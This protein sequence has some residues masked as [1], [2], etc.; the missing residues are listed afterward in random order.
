MN[1]DGINQTNLTNNSALERRSTWSPDGTKIAFESNRD[2]DREIYQMSSTGDNPINLTNS[3]G[4]DRQ[5]HWSSDGTKIAFI[6]KRD[7]NLEVYVM[8]S[9]GTDSTRLTNESSNDGF[10]A[11]SNDGTKIAFDS[12]RDG[13]NEIYV[14]D[15][16]RFIQGY[17][18]DAAVDFK[19]LG[20]TV[21]VDP[22]YFTTPPDITPTTTCA[23]TTGDISG[24]VD[25]DADGIIL[26]VYN[27]SGS[28]KTYGIREVGSSYS[29]TSLGLRGNENT[30]YL[31]GLNASKEFQAYLETTDVKIYL[32]GQTKGS[33]V[34]Y[35]DDKVVTDPTT[36]SWQLLDADDY[37]IP[38]AANGLVFLAEQPVAGGEPGFR[39][40]DSTDDWNK[41]VS[42]VTHIQAGVGLDDDNQW[43][44]YMQETSAD[45]FIAAYTLPIGMDVHADMDVLIRQADGSV[46]TT[47]ATNVANSSNITDTTW[48][49]FT[50]TYSFPGYT[51]VDQTDYLEIDLFA[52]ATSNTFTEDVFVDFRIDDPSLPEADQTRIKEVTP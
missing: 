39:H 25:A 22:A 30:M 29:T 49:S 3:A 43:G 50:A 37:S 47:I 17:I 15:A 32:V 45:V 6:S 26:L 46:R 18:T 44:E 4:D 11:W 1:A 8:N 48:R 42:S 35:V 14:M 21:G 33:V 19:M 16:S 20:Y 36:G 38:T 28:P 23:W 13:N 5:A 34:Y 7:G 2:G 40:G 9:D 51:V 10:P 12:I 41:K 27:S 52:E 31:V 24:Q